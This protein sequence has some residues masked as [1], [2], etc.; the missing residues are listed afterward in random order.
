MSATVARRLFYAGLALAVLALDQWSKSWAATRLRTGPDVDVIPGLLRFTYAENPG[1]AFSFLNS[2]A[3]TT[4]W[5]L[6]AFSSLAALVVVGFAL[7]TPA[8][9]WRLQATFAF[10][11]AGIVGNLIDRVQ[12]GRVIDFIDAYVN[13]HH[14]PTFNVA[15]SAITVGAV[16]LALELFR[17]EEPAHSR[18]TATPGEG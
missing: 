6:A 9:A 14:W 8:F 7:R 16:F 4:R 1:I 11:F 3:Q 18:E 10:L 15:D 13:T 2:G 17:H 5:G 12:T